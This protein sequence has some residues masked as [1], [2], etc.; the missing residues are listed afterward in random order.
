M[1]NTKNYY[2]YSDESGVFSKNDSFFIITFLVFKSK[3]SISKSKTLFK[4]KEDRIKKIKN[5]NPEEEL[6]GFTLSLN[7]KKSIIKSF[8][9]IDK[10]FVKIDISKIKEEIIDNKANRRRFLNWV[11]AVSLKKYFQNEI[12]KNILSKEDIL[13][14]FLNLDNISTKTSG[15]YTLEESI[16]RELFWEVYNSDCDITIPPFFKNIGSLTLSY[17]DSKYSPLIRMVDVLSNYIYVNIKKGNKLDEFLK[18]YF[19]F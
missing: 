12:K 8:N 17:L 5:I 14:I 11:I 7:L 15:K 4:S 2:I 9:T 1:N 13:N 10:F 16:I 19:P 3:K 6:K 18:F